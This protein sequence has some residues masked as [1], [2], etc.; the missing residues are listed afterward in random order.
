MDL[1]DLTRILFIFVL[2]IGISNSLED[3]LEGEEKTV[4][5]A[6]IDS[7]FRSQKV[8]M[9]WNKARYLHE[10]SVYYYFFPIH[11]FWYKSTRIFVY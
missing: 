1:S 10:I 4:N 8:N 3:Q 11:I 7:P 5:Y 6:A 9:I 2:T